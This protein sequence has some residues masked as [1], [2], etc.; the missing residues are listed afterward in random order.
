MRTHGPEDLRI[1]SDPIG[2][3]RKLFAREHFGGPHLAARLLSDL[4][5]LD[6]LPGRVD[7]IGSWW[8]VGSQRDWLR[9]SDGIISKRPFHAIVPFPAAGQNSCRAE[10]LLTAF[11]DAVATY[12]TDGLE[13]IVRDRDHEDLPAVWHDDA[14]SYEQGR[15]V[16]FKVSS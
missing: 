15:F 13:W 9:S 1:V 6:A 8:F 4:I 3:L 14:R 7:R 2:T 16:A 12:G 11:A 5:L 10:A